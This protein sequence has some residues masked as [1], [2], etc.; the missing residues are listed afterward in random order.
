MSVEH[1]AAMNGLLAGSP[2][3]REMCA[4]LARDYLVTY[5][6]SDGPG[7]EPVAWRMELE[8][9]HGVRVALGLA[10]QPAD[11]TIRGDYAAMVRAAQ[12]ARAGRLPETGAA[13]EG[14]PAVVGQVAQVLAAARAAATVDVEFPA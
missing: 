13:I 6:L 11:V 1:V 12:A 14:D 3:V 10:S 5:L 7:G 4:R 8:R 2:E 9:L